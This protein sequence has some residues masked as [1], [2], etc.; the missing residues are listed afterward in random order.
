L[1]GIHIKGGV[2]RKSKFPGAVREIPVRDINE[3]A[4]YCESNLGFTVDCWS[5]G[6]DESGVRVLPRI[7]TEE[8][9]MQ[10]W[11]VTLRKKPKN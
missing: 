8:S 11:N 10:T 2:A 3:A 7:G 9:R 1:L 4:A 6:P 5:R